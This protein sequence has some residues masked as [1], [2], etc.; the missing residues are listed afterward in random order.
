M[1]NRLGFKW[2]VALAMAS[3]LLLTSSFSDNIGVARAG[4]DSSDMVEHELTRAT[5]LLYVGTDEGDLLPV[6]SA[7]EFKRN[8][9]NTCYT[10]YFLT[11]AECVMDDRTLDQVLEEFGQE[12]VKFISEAD[13][14]WTFNDGGHKLFYPAKVAISRDRKVIV[15]ILIGRTK[16]RG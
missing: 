14:Y 3:A 7:V 9:G 12:M 2:I 15:A 4:E 5:A 8:K 13:F 16:Y 6:C 11:T 1:K 10:Y